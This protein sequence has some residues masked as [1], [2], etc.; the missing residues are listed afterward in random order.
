MKTKTGDFILAALL[1]IGLILTLDALTNSIDIEKFAWD[2]RYYITMAQDG[3]NARP[4]ASPFVYRYATPL[5]VY[6][7]HHWLGFSIE[8]I[9]RGIAYLGTFLQLMGV[10]TFVDV[11]SRKAAFI[12][13]LV[14]GFS[15]FHVKFL[16]FDVYRPDHLTYAFI[17]LATYFAFQ[18]KFI[19]LLIV[20]VVASQTREFAIIPLI[21]YLCSFARTEERRSFLAQSWVSLLT[22]VLALGLPRLLIP[23]TMDFQFVSL[24][25]DGLLR[26]LLAPLILTRDINFI[27]TLV[28]YLLP[29]LMIASLS[30]IELAYSSLSDEIRKFLFVY[31]VLVIFFSF[32]GGTDF[33][34]FATYLFVPQIILLGVL[35][36]KSSNFLMAI[37]L[38]AV[39]IFNLL[40]LPV[41]LSSVEAYRDFYGGYDV[42]LSA[43]TLW[44]IVELVCFILLGWFVRKKFPFEPALS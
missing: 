19:P 23:V 2:F 43:S 16:L 8:S 37:M 38:I 6:A 41:P 3:F 11:R 32:L 7:I 13:L 44:R 27:Y 28:A 34:R 35:A 12:A 1:S 40:W 14:I 26:G 24:T 15:L 18:R 31:T 36:D 29:I 9:F 42:R 22:L 30:Q 39:F 17:L 21:S 5:L 10:F 4:F 20:T 25:P 33:P